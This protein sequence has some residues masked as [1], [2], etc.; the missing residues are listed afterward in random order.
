MELFSAALSAPEPPF[1]VLQVH[2]PGGVGKTAL[3]QGFAEVATAAGALAVR[4]DARH[5]EPSPAGFLGGLRQALDLPED[6]QS[7]EACALVRAMTESVLR[8]ALKTDDAGEL[9]MWLRSLSFVEDSAHGLTLHDLA[10]DALDS[11]LRWRDP[12]RYEELRHRLH[13]H[14][15]NQIQDST[16]D[17]QQRL[18]LDGLFLHRMS[19]ALRGAYDWDGMDRARV[20]AAARPGPANM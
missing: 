7:L 12:T 15:G 17:L 14:L 10:R 2:G 19:P 6:R 4:L 13:E 3:L 1:T 11:D 18:M 16:G 9:F 8:I 5:H 20:E